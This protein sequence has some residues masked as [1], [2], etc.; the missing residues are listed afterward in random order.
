MGYVIINHYFINSFLEHIGCMSEVSYTFF[1]FS[2]SLVHGTAFI[3]PT[4]PYNLKLSL[5]FTYEQ[6]F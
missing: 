5:L 3:H 1:E 4:H 2:I 6:D